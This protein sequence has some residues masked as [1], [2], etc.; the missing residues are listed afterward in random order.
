MNVFATY[1]QMRKQ[2]MNVPYYFL[3]FPDVTSQQTKWYKV[4][5]YY[6]VNCRVG[7]PKAELI[8]R[9]VNCKDRPT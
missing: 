9:V 4:A 8:G 6:A 3:V 1:I 2:D 5:R 7:M